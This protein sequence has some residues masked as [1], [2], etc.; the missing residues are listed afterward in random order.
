[1]QIPVEIAWHNM[2]PAPHVEKRVNARVERLEQFFDRIMGCHVVVEA[3][4]Q[5]HQ[6]G[7]QY[8]VRLS[9]TLP[10]G[11]LAV[12]RN[13]GNVNAHTD[14]LVAVRDAFDAMERQLRRWKEEH[15]GRP[16]VH[17]GAL[18]GRVVEIDH[19]RDFGQIAAADGRLVYFHRNAV[20]SGDFDG[21]SVGDTV[22]LVVDRGEDAEGAHASTVRTIAPGAYVERRG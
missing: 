9:L 8:E 15:K 12:N 1:M 22:E 18:Q 11:E 17:A 13:P 3:P 7:N 6:Q 4:H 16:E 10:G 20:V 19:K 5:R 14:V 2:D 21:M